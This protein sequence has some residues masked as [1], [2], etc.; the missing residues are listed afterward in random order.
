MVADYAASCFENAKS[1]G[2]NILRQKVPKIRSVKLKAF[3]S[4]S[5]LPSSSNIQI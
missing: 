2:F 4:K 1:L 5:D 3:D